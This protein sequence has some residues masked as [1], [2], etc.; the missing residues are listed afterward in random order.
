[1]NMHV[2]MTAQRLLMNMY[3]GT[4]DTRSGK[5]LHFHRQL[6]GVGIVHGLA[7]NDEILAIF[8]VGLG[9]GS[10]QLQLGGVAIFTVGGMIGMTLRRR[11][12][13]PGI[14]V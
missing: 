7:S 3:T 13:L 6:F 1:M 12:N 14:K 4:A 5:K 8:V 10:L 11:G 2:N 9:V